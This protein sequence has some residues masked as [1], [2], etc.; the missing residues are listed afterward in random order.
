MNNKTC[1]QGNW[2]I[3]PRTQPGVVAEVHDGLRVLGAILSNV[4][5]DEREE[6]RPV[7]GLNAQGCSTEK[8]DNSSE[9]STHHYSYC[10]LLA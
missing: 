4:V 1:C 8:D 3:H 9:T 10:A 7:L 2:T 5:A 6:G